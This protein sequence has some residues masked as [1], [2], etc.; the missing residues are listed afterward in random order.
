MA[1]LVPDMVKLHSNIVFTYNLTQMFIPEAA[2]SDKEPVK[3]ENNKRAK[4]Q[5]FSFPALKS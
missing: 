3:Q 2:P 4:F 5:L 1:P